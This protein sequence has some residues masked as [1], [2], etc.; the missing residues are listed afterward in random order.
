MHI[1]RWITAIILIPVLIYIIGYSNP[2]IFHLLLIV[3]SFI[4][5]WEFLSITGNSEK[6]E[7]VLILF[8]LIVLLFAI[9][10]MRQALLI[11][12]IMV[13]WIA[14][15]L[16]FR[17]IMKKEPSHAETYKI[18]I[19]ALSFIYICL[20]LSM[21]SLIYLYPSGRM[22]VFF[23]LLVVFASD[24]G[25]FYG[26]RFLGRHALHP[27]SPKKTIE[28]AVCGF[29]S[30]FIAGV[31]FIKIMKI[32]ELN[33]GVMI[34][35]ALLSLFSQ[36]GDLVESMFKRNHGVKDSGSILPGHGGVLDR[37][38]GLLLSIPVL[39]VYIFLR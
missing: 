25:A 2:L 23:I 34:I 4:A 10:Y 27:L 6:W 15:P 14:V 35:I 20:P 18:S 39:Y 22:W 8:P 33:T 31:Y 29:F 36:F 11:P 37:I 24:T 38:D 21:L 30:G 13:L 26:G 16:F 28:G 12:P 1:K 17:I 32:S 5:T 9:V 3:T 7:I 19:N